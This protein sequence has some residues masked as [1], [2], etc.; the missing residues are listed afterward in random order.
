LIEVFVFHRSIFAA[1]KLAREE[2]YAKQS[3]DEEEHHTEH[4]Q[5]T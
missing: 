4:D 3:K 2:G 1:M 5:R